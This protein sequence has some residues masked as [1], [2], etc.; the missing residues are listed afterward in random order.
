MRA[1]LYLRVSTDTQTTDNQERELREVA[2][3]S[4][5][6]ITEV[7]RDAGISG[8]SPRRP[9]FDALCK[10]AARRR[11]DV[12]MAWS[13]DRLGRSLQG[14]VAFLSDLHA[15]RVDL[16]LHQQGI[17]T[18]TP[19]GKAM[20]QMMGVFAEF[21]RAMIS[22]RVKAGLSTARAKGKKLGRPSLSATTEAAILRDL[23]GETGSLRALAAK[24]GVSVGTV[25]RLRRE[26]L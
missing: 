11:F 25:H 6:T 10:D 4:G 14:L 24:H 16:F 15:L 26:R 21:E 2:E 8:A 23:Q 1:A 9:A 5:W 20:F 18:T 17:D 13:V 12:V 3:R 22:E 19:A 7:Y